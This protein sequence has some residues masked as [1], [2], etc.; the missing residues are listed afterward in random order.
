MADRFELS[1]LDGQKF[2]TNVSEKVLSILRTNPSYV[3]T[4]VSEQYAEKYLL[5]NYSSKKSVVLVIASILSFTG[6]LSIFDNQEAF[7]FKTFVLDL[8]LNCLDEDEFGLKVSLRCAALIFQHTELQ[9]V[10]Q[11]I[12]GFVSIGT[13]SQ[14]PERWRNNLFDAHP[15]LQKPWKKSV[16]KYQRLEATERA[17]LERDWFYLLD[18][19]VFSIISE[20]LISIYIDLL[21]ITLQQIPT[22]RYLLTLY[23]SLLVLP[24]LEELELKGLASQI[25]LLRFYMHFPMDEFTGEEL[26]RSE[27]VSKYTQKMYKLQNLAYGYRA[28]EKLLPLALA[29]FSSIAGDLEDLVESAN[30]NDLAEFCAELGLIQPQNSGISRS[31]LI[32]ALKDYAF[33]QPWDISLHVDYAALN[34]DSDPK[35]SS[36]FLPDSLSIKATAQYLSLREF[37]FRQY[38]IYRSVHLLSI[39]TVLEKW[40]KDLQSSTYT[41][42]YETDSIKAEIYEIKELVVRSQSSNFLGDRGLMEVHIEAFCQ[43][44]KPIEKQSSDALVLLAH[45]NGEKIQKVNKCNSFEIIGK[46]DSRSKGLKI[47]SEDDKD[48]DSDYSSYKGYRGAR[49]I[50]I[51]ADLKEAPAGFNF[52]IILTDADQKILDLLSSAALET[53]LLPS[54]LSDIFL[55]FGIVG[56]NVITLPETL[57]VGALLSEAQVASEALEIEPN[58]DVPPFK[59]ANPLNGKYTEFQSTR[60]DEEG[61]H[62]PEN[63]TPR[64]IQAIVSSVISPLSVISRHSDASQRS[65]DIVANIIYILTKNFSTEKTLIISKRKQLVDDT[66]DKLVSMGVDSSSLLL[67]EEKGPY[68]YEH[69]FSIKEGL[70]EE[71]GRLAVHLGFSK[72]Y[73]NS[74]STASLFW[75]KHIL[76]LIQSQSEGELQEISSLFSL[77]SPQKSKQKLL[78][79]FNKLES[80]EPLEVLRDIHRQDWLP[81]SHLTQIVGCDTQ[82]ISQILKK[83]VDYQNIVFI[84][85]ES[86]PEA[87]STALFC[88]G[89]RRLIMLGDERVSPEH[90]IYFQ[91]NC[92]QSLFTRLLALPNGSAP[93]YEITDYSD[94][95]PELGPR[96]TGNHVMRSFNPGLLHVC[97]FLN[98]SGTEETNGLF[99][100]SNHEEARYTVLLYQYLR[101][102]GYPTEK[103]S[104]CTPYRAQCAVISKI[105]KKNMTDDLRKKIFGMPNIGLS[106]D[107]P[108]NDYILFSGVRSSSDQLPCVVTE[109]PRAKLGYYLIGNRDVFGLDGKVRDIISQQKDGILQVVVGE[110]YSLQERKNTKGIPIVGLEHLDQYVREM[111]NQRLQFEKSRK[112]TTSS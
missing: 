17:I 58:D 25:N 36:S 24:K 22:R 5:P 28:D 40:L 109:K 21:I 26:S 100:Y 111:T 72:G 49:K 12:S 35:N 61:P 82:N 75:K 97:Q 68:G 88:S 99:D 63:F 74:C 44:P 107:L 90:G 85:S 103:I 11:S 34:L 29:N 93:I 33:L 78:S 15:A 105:L 2:D 56:S 31:L 39:K 91:T 101:L 19:K 69:I 13:W 18:K 110:L 7:S 76:P 79:I 50:L 37:W 104:I 53:A 65:V 45:F 16:K 51:K 62:L 106:G 112:P 86:I 20:D 83:N 41:G 95:R 42:N 59:L 87:Q 70:L 14:I 27:A 46:K 3:S 4:L 52:L 108:D 89:I 8:F 6:D 54:W 80:L 98:I 9:Q 48:S 60:M 1:K 71:V 92:H 23:Q 55:G 57:E 67:M 32:R 10:R 84:D 81:R 66:F 102:L 96:N 30:D 64:E 94:Y 47:D 38:L 77:S 43:G 73:G